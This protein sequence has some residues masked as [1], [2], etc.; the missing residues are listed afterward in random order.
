M[1]LATQRSAIL[2]ILQ[3]VTDI[4]VVHDYERW[5]NDW[6]RYLETFSTTIGGIK[7]IQGWTI[8]RES[9][10]E[11]PFVQSQNQ[12][13]HIWVIRGYRGLD[14]TAG[15]ETS[16]QDLCESVCSELR[17]RPTLNGTAERDSGPPQVRVVEH[18]LFGGVTCHHVEITFRAYELHDYTE[19]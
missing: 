15:S 14:D 2:S 5:L 9:T 3:G 13:G 12:R 19:V 18:R 10:G 11:T 8:T 1:S 6:N 7:R 17:R 4:G 16:F